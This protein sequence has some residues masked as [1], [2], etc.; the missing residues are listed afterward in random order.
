MSVVTTRG[1][2]LS[3]AKPNIYVLFVRGESTI[4][5]FTRYSDM[6]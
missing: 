4:Y 2:L 6:D 1:I 5:N 3:A